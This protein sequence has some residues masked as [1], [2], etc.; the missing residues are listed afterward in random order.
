[1]RLDNYLEKSDLMT[2]SLKC[3]LCDF[4]TKIFY[5]EKNREFY[6]CDNCFSIMLN[7]INYI[8]NKDEKERYETHNNDV[9]DI[10]YQNFVSPI[11]KSVKKDY[12]PSHIGLDFGAGTGPVITSLL[13]KEGYKL[14]LYDPYFHNYPKNLNKKYDFIVCCEV[15]E[16]FYN[17]F[18]EFK[19][20]SE[21]LNS[22]GRLYCMTSLYDESINFEDWYYKN[23]ETHVFFYHKKALEWICAKFEFAKVKISD[24]LIIFS[25]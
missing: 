21:I 3:L 7:P 11:V 18:E 4:D 8:S 25:K 24:R 22:N 15:I 19:L 1:M 6:K 2:T 17:P 9:D 12:K 5:K 10:R 20:M 16:H 13:E 23:D 14:N